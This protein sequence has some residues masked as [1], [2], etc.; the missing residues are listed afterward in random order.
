MSGAPR[1]NPVK[2]ASREG[3]DS[4]GSESKMLFRGGPLF[5]G[6]LTRQ[7]STLVPSGHVTPVLWLLLFMPPLPCN[8]CKRVRGKKSGRGKGEWGRERASKDEIYKQGARNTTK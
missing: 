3:V 2:A 1:A 4:S 8:T 7:P 6:G 5:T